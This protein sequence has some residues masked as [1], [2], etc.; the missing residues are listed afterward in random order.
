[1]EHKTVVTYITGA[2]LGSSCYLIDWYCGSVWYRVMVDFGV[3]FDKWDGDDSP[4]LKKFYGRKVV[5][6]KLD[7]E[8]FAVK[9]I[10]AVLV[11]HNHLD[12]CGG[13]PMLLEYM[14]DDAKIWSTTLSSDILEHVFE[15]TITNSPYLFDI[16]EKD[17][18]L[19]RRAVVPYGEFELLPCLKIFVKDAGHLLGAASFIFDLG[20]GDKGIITGD[21]ALHD[22]PIA[23]GTSLC[24]QVLPEEWLPN[25]VFG[26]DFTHGGAD[27]PRL[28]YDDE[29]QKLCDKVA[30]VLAGGGKVVIPAFAH[31]RGQHIAASLAR[32]G[33]TVYIDGAI[34]P[35]M[36]TYA[37]HVEFDFP[38]DRIR[39]IEKG[40][41]GRIQREHLL[42]SK[43]PVVVVTTSGMGD[44]GPIGSYLR[45]WGADPNNAILFTSYLTPRSTGDRILKLSKKYECFTVEISD[46]REG[47]I[48]VDIAA[49]VARYHLTAHA[50]IFDF[51]RFVEDMVTAR[52]GTKLKVLALTHGTEKTLSYAHELFDKY[53]QRVVIPFP[54]QQIE[55]TGNNCDD[56]D[57]TAVAS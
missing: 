9:K 45:A 2:L 47:I 29:M 5:A 25:H 6:P 54:G 33:F 38:L 34:G 43:E 22:Q 28:N 12:H 52:G 21:I 57:M 30:E 40:P 31:G 26:A 11:T 37:Q 4:L 16:F 42:K 55:V 41:E 27:H 7:S 17:E 23:L 14:T 44:G 56:T 13:L 18:A 3:E 49:F 39:V 1:V 24:S 48:E 50:D 46:E 53:A 8:M 36:R 20:N 51:A 32:L 19:S 35:V 10:D 15:D